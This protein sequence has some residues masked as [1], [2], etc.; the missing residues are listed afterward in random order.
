MVTIDTCINVLVK[1]HFQLCFP[2]P[3]SV[4][5]GGQWNSFLEFLGGP[6]GQGKHLVIELTLL[7]ELLCFLSLRTQFFTKWDSKERGAWDLFIT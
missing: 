2:P 7:Y 3:T 6:A 4:Y 1:D 5:S